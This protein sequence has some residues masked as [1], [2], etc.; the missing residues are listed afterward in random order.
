[1]RIF[2][3]LA[4][5]LIGGCFANPIVPTDSSRTVVIDFPEVGTTH[6]VSIGQTVA[7]K[8]IHRTILELEVL[9]TATFGKEEGEVSAWTC[10]YTTAPSAAAQ[11]GVYD[12][13]WMGQQITAS[14]FGPFFAALTESDGAVS[15][16]CRGE[17]IMVDICRNDD[18]QSYFM[19]NPDHPSG[20]VVLPLEQDF[21]HFRTDIVKVESG[22]NYLLEFT[23]GGHDE[24]KIRFVY[25]ELLGGDS[26]RESTREV[27]FD[28]SELP[29]V[30]F[31]DLAIEI[32][33]VKSTYIRYKLLSN[34]SDS[35]APG[36]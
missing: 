5:A 34:F 12:K 36:Q 13:V 4:T 32:V 6:Q 27:E 9:E 31:Q 15:G 11:R 26:R 29:Q 2:L 21:D 17:T 35:P 3:V 1:M 23:Y 19:V 16:V 14:C 8:G 33:E 24:E 7:A 22:E 20:K 30:R 25:R 10:G 18:D 28:M